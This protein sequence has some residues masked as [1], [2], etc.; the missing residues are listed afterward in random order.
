[1][2]TEPIVVRGTVTPDGALK[3][4]QTLPLSPGPVQVTIQPAPTSASVGKDWWQQLQEARAVLDCR[5][6]GFRSQAE[7]EAEHEA[8]R[9]EESAGG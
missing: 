2:A 7:I 4:D 6:T 8:F 3:L 1:M 5:G 9:A